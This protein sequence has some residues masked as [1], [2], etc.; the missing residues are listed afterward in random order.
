MVRNSRFD[1]LLSAGPAARSGAPPCTAADVEARRRVA[2]ESAECRTA[3]ARDSGCG[4]VTDPFLNGWFGDAAAARPVRNPQETS[5]PVAFACLHRHPVSRWLPAWA[6]QNLHHLRLTRRQATWSA[7][8]SPTISAQ[9][10]VPDNV[11]R[12]LPYSLSRL[13]LGLL[14]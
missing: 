3:C 1:P 5:P 10:A 4:A 8:D 6:V 13:A 14:P 9:S 12:R 7:G 11:D 2:A